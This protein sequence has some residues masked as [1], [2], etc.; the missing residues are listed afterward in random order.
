MTKPEFVRQADAICE[1]GRHSFEGDLENLLKNT[2]KSGPEALEALRAPEAEV[3]INEFF[4]PVHEEEI[5][6][7]SALGA[8]GGDQ[9][10]VSAILE[11]VRRGLAEATRHPLKLSQTPLP[12]FPGF[13]EAAKLAT[14]FGFS[15]CGLT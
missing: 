8:P 14:A 6:Q 10:S 9:E 4:I 1:R 3:L 5:E 15:Q 13:D 2:G 11:A 12:S 7:V